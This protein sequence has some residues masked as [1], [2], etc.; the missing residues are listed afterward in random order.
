[1]SLDP[2]SL[3]TGLLEAYSPSAQESGAVAY[4]V[5]QMAALGYDA[6]ADGAGNAVGSRGEGPH[7]IMLLGH[8]D[9]VPGQIAVEQ[10]GDDLY[11]RG[12]VDAKGPLACFTAAAAAAQVPPGWK[13]TVIGAVGEEGSSPGARFVRD[14]YARP[15]MVIIGEPSG[16]DHVTLGYKGSLWLKYELNQ[17]LA[18]TA[19]RTTGACE[20]AVSFWNSLQA[21]AAE[22]NAAQPRIF[23]Q[24][25]PALRGMHS[26]NDGF[27]DQAR[28]AINLRLPPG[29]DCGAL[30][31]QLA[32][33][34][35]PAQLE[36]EDCTPA[37]RGEKNSPLVRAFLAGIRQAGG[38]PGFTLKTGTSDMNIV[39]PAWGCPI[40]A[41]GPGDSDLDHTPHEHIQVSEYLKGIQVLT[42]ALELAMGSG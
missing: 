25:T 28:L 27:Q 22:R 33:L 13:L 36:I 41:Y 38:Q 42:R 18:H 15:A 16:W 11:G 9:T 24:L 29:V 30:A 3:L 31:A 8:I 12:A 20:Q 5:R 1:V 35:G 23:D 6:R 26:S 10:D 7:E 34:A 40:A 21:L 32:E 4:L 14:S 39:G 37:Y 2:V 17:P 19:A